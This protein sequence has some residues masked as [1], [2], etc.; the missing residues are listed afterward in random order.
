[1]SCCLESCSKMFSKMLSPSII[2]NPNFD[3][4]AML[5]M[6]QNLFLA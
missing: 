6:S 4:M 3:S 5:V 2:K 1:M